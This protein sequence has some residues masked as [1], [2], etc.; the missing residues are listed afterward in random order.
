M[1]LYL[2]EAKYT[3][4]EKQALYSDYETET[5]LIS[6]VETKLGQQMKDNGCKVELLIAFDGVGNILAQH[7]H[8]K[9]E[10]IELSNRLVWVTTDSQ[11]EHPQMQKY[12]TADEAESYYHIRRGEAMDN[13][14]TDVKTFF[15]MIINGSYVGLHDYWMRPVEAPEPEPEPEEVTE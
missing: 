15:R 7:Y 8:T 6:A 11:G 1:G 13:E 2:L 5:E 4:E 12:D 3:T 10:T 14:H 9:D